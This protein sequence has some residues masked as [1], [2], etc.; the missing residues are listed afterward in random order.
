M[1]SASVTQVGVGSAG[2]N[3][4][5][6]NQSPIHPAM[7]LPT[8]HL[9]TSSSSSSPHS[10][11]PIEPEPDRRGNL[12]YKLRILPVSASRFSRL[13]TQLKWRLAEGGGL[14][15]YEI[16]VLDDGTLVGLPQEEMKSS[17][18]QLAMMGRALGAACEV[19][20][21]ILVERGEAGAVETPMG[22]PSSLSASSPSSHETLRSNLAPYRHRRG[23]S[24][25][26]RSGGLDNIVGLRSLDN[27]EAHKV[28]GDSQLERDCLYQWSFGIQSETG[29]DG[30]TSLSENEAVVQD[31]PTN[32]SEDAGDR[33]SGAAPGSDGPEEDDD[34]GFAFS[35]SLSDDDASSQPPPSRQQ[36]PKWSSRRP[37]RSINNSPW[38]KF[39]GASPSPVLSAVATASTGASDALTST[40]ADSC[41]RSGSS[42]LSTPPLDAT[43]IDSSPA[44]GTSPMSS[45]SSL[46]QP[47][48]FRD[49]LQHPH[50]LAAAD[51]EGA[52][53]FTNNISTAKC[54]AASISPPLTKTAPH[55]GHSN[56]V[57]A[58]CNDN[59]KYSVAEHSFEFGADWPGSLL[60]LDAEPKK[61]GRGMKP[62]MRGARIER[63][64]R[65]VAEH[66]AKER[67][68]E[69]LLS[70]LS[71]VS[72][73]M[74]A[75]PLLVERQRWWRYSGLTLERDLPFYDPAKQSWVREVI[76][77]LTIQEAMELSQSWSPD[78][79]KLDHGTGNEDIDSGLR[80]RGG[81]YNMHGLK[82]HVE[83][84]GDA[85]HP[86]RENVD[87]AADKENMAELYA[88]LS[89]KAYHRRRKKDRKK[90]E[91]VEKTAAAAAL[92]ARTDSSGVHGRAFESD[93][94]PCVLRPSYLPPPASAI[95]IPR[96]SNGQTNG[97]SPLGSKS[98]VQSKTSS[99]HPL[100]Q[101]SRLSLGSD[102]DSDGDEDND[103]DALGMGLTLN[104]DEVFPE[105]T[106]SAERSRQ[107]VESAVATDTA[108]VNDG[109]GSLPSGQGTEPAAPA[110][111]IIVEAVLSLPR[112]AAALV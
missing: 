14:A 33:A 97:A 36:A 65:R 10:F 42:T 79:S 98:S 13:V 55:N 62:S 5:P 92:A 90:Q 91:L 51:C 100:S 44:R 1:H 48:L 22:T 67:E 64:A 70:S 27:A 23:T 88:G 83:G 7:S 78:R 96:Q 35:L 39:A 94:R 9:S 57:K 20:R 87:S 40:R 84:D 112:Q 6:S 95:S 21:C 12:E 77:W 18:A 69:G 89:R 105:A 110:L 29:S 32:S 46:A 17:L 58:T 11:S 16:G 54:H 45:V 103:D 76:D 61:G 59:D 47:R 2:S 93:H 107:P 71:I 72:P 85:Q 63:R 81:R 15:V 25:K 3:A 50:N 24:S 108:A 38:Q 49:H 68:G 26:N 99:S 19:R 41:D 53:R 34:D 75:E 109:G 82:C 102:S 43:D 4:S 37:S 101:S 66:K 28:L 111:R 80:D 104:I 30:T 106:S 73:D 52:L 86:N 74:D 56:F 60:G 31:E 8:S